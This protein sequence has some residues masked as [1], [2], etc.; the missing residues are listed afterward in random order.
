[1]DAASAY[2]AYR[3]HRHAAESYARRADA[4]RERAEQHRR[5]AF[6]GLPPYLGVVALATG[7]V[8]AAT[9]LGVRA[10]NAHMSAKEA[11]AEERLRQVR[12]KAAQ[13]QAAIR[14]AKE[15]AK[16]K[17]A[18]ELAPATKQAVL[19]SIRAWL[20]GESSEFAK[21]G[22]LDGYSDATSDD[23]ALR[24]Y[25]RLV[26]DDPVARVF[27][28]SHHP[29]KDVKI[30]RSFSH[31]PWGTPSR[32]STPSRTRLVAYVGDQNMVLYEFPV[33]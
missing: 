19:A 13:E 5:S 25:V 16:R 11:A 8:V 22:E 14:A 31:E 10:F 32:T 20:K 27:V 28:Q 15:E 24:L 29:T 18:T 33:R 23:E 1:M 17:K 12:I 21:N 2:S 3:K 6:G 30:L 4:H 26:W 7:G 9:A